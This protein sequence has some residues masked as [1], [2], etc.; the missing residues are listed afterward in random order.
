MGFSENFLELAGEPWRSLSTPWRERV[1]CLEPCI[2]LAR[3]WW[4][5]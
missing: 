3:R 2:H 5:V 1:R 4:V